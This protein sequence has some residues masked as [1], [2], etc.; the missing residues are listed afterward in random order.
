VQEDWRKAR[1]W[2][3]LCQQMFACAFNRCAAPHVR[4]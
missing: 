3:K 4:E 1:F 2:N